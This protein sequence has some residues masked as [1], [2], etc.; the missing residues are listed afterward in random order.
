ML[1]GLTTVTYRTADIEAAK[2][3]CAELLGIEPY[4]EVP[5]AY[6][7]FRAPDASDSGL[8]VTKE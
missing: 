3:W 2:K 5:G 4:F 6:A 7:E 8:L 1:A